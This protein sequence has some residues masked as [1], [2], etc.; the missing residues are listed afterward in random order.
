MPHRSVARASGTP[1]SLGPRTARL[2]KRLRGASRAPRRFSLKSEISILYS[3]LFAVGSIDLVP[4]ALGRRRQLCAAVQRLE[5]GAPREGD[6]GVTDDD[7]LVEIDVRGH[8][9]AVEVSA[10]TSRLQRPAHDYRAEELESALH[11]QVALD[12]E[13]SLAAAAIERGVARRIDDR[14]VVDAGT[15]VG[16]HRLAPIACVVD[17]AHAV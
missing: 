16:F 13:N 11:L 12:E 17:V 8:D 4:C 9:A 3:D 7:V 5:N 1:R 2:S 14:V 6:H 10:R 15:A